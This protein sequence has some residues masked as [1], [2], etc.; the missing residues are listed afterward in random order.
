VD[1]WTLVPVQTLQVEDRARPYFPYKI[2]RP[3][4]GKQRL[5]CTDHKIDECNRSTKT[6]TIVHLLKQYIFQTKLRNG[7]YKIWRARSSFNEIIDLHAGTSSSV[8]L[9]LYLRLCICIN[10]VLW[11]LVYVSWNI[12]RCLGQYV[13][14]SNNKQ[15]PQTIC[16]FMK[17]SAS[18]PV[19]MKISQIVRNYLKEK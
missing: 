14:V 12:S 5:V 16:S 13:G 18:I 17:L 10:I 2:T 3:E 6:L 19:R 4:Q 15:F 9:R 7:L 11:N 8:C 1:V